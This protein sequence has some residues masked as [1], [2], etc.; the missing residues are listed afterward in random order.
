MGSQCAARARRGSWSSA[1]ATSSES[2]T[3]TA[4]GPPPFNIYSSSKS[5]TSTAYGLILSDFG[6][7]P[8]AGQQVTIARHQGLQYGVAARVAAVARLRKAEITVRNLL[9]MASGLD[10]QNPPEKDH[11]FEWRSATSRVADGQAPE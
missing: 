9:N 11:P 4:I 8:L 3:R 10:T 2:G 5:Y 6:N 1:A 7:G